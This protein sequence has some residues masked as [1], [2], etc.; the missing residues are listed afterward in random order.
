[1]E[2]HNGSLQQTCRNADINVFFDINYCDFC[3]CT[4]LFGSEDSAVFVEQIHNNCWNT[5]LKNL[6]NFDYLFVIWENGIP[7]LPPQQLQ[8]H[9][10]LN[11][12]K[13]I[14]Q[15]YCRCQGPE[16]GT[17]IACDNSD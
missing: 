13:W 4:F 14:N 6:R 11:K 7:D 9:Q 8:C 5:A 16:E 2:E 10:V 17:M 12:V 1:M 3:V 15:S